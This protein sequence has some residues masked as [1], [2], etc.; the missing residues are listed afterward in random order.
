[1]NYCLCF[2]EKKKKELAPSNS[3]S[4]TGLQHYTRWTT[5]LHKMVSS[6]HE[7]YYITVV[8]D[9]RLLLAFVCVIVLH[10]LLSVYVSLCTSLDSH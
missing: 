5:A 9:C 4:I 6:R 2:A 7:L 8:H 3:D 1:M 10:V